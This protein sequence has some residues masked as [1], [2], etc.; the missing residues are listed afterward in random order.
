MNCGVSQ[1][2]LDAAVERDDLIGA[3]ESADEIKYDL[4]LPE[5][6]DGLNITWSSSNPM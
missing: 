6:V 1:T 2:K 3:N 4:E 5:S